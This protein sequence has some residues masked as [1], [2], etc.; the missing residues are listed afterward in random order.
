MLLHRVKILSSYFVHIQPFLISSS[1]ALLCLHVTCLGF[2]LL[3]CSLIDTY[4]YLFQGEC[5]QIDPQWFSL[6]SGVFSFCRGRR[7]ILFS[8]IRIESGKFYEAGQA[9]HLAQPM[10]WQPGCHCASHLCM[11]GRYAWLW[12]PCAVFSPADSGV[13]IASLFWT[14]GTELQR[15]MVCVQSGE[16]QEHG[17]SPRANSETVAQPKIFLSFAP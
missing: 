10:L 3:I 16:V 9:M 13:C 2:C 17:M 5:K 15:Q 11:C 7:G 12:W 1:R 6:T 14:C 4:K 8:K